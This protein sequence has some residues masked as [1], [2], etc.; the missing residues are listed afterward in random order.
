[1]VRPW[2]KVTAG[3]AAGLFFVYVAVSAAWHGTDT[4][5]QFLRDHHIFAIQALAILVLVLFLAWV[6]LWVRTFSWFDRHGSSVELKVVHRRVGTPI[7]KPGD[8]IAIAIQ[9]AAN[10]ILI[11]AMFAAIF[12]MHD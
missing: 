6:T 1:M 10:T 11:A 8:A 4:I 3:A 7:E 12:L 2:V 5:G 9:Y